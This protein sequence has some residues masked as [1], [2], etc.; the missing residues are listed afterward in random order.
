MSA[1]SVSATGAIPRLIIGLGA[2]GLAT[3]RYCQRRHWSFDL[4]DTRAE[5]PGVDQVRAAFP[6]ANVYT[7]SL[8]A[9][10]L[11]R[12]QQLVVS[13]GVA[14]STPA[15]QQAMA[16]G[17][18][19]VGDVE[20]F[21]QVCRRPVIAITGSNGKSTVTRLVACLLEAAGY[22][23]EVGGNIGIPVLDLLEHPQPD[24][25]VL[26]LSSFQLETTFS[27]KAAASVLLNFSE[28][29]MDRYPGMAEYLS[30]KQRIFQHCQAVVVNRDDPASSPPNT[31]LQPLTFGLSDPAIQNP[32]AHQNDY[33]LRQ[34]SCEGKQGWWIVKGQTCLVHSSHI[35]LKGKH[36]LSNVMA[37]LA[38]LDACG[39]NSQE[40]WPALAE[41]KGLSHRCQFIDSIEGVDFINDS[42]GTN[43]GSTLAA[44]D[45]LASDSGSYVHLLLGGDGKGQN[46]SPL[47]AALQRLRVKAYCYGESAAVLAPLL[48]DVTSCQSTST[49][50]E[51]LALAMEAALAGDTVLLS[52]ACASFD[53]YA[54]YVERGHHFET[55]VRNRGT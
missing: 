16:N 52:P 37:G 39:V 20:L 47:V 7:G 36:N 30:A 4:C 29:H 44:I 23:V 3:A 28:D 21:L 14:L 24:F 15:L 19:V 45:G 31:T 11:C 2:T 13:P 17:V 8:S 10:L 33:G 18:S 32:D 55:L 25:Y 27:L 49:L 50:D 34:G 38:L 51:A 26:E 48:S 53:Q 22:Q 12:Y 35:A 5:P 1:P 43:V 54:S 41:F 40:A 46:F 42:K 6:E 9:D